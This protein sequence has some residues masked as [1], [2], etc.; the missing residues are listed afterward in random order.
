MRRKKG[1]RWYNEVYRNPKGDYEKD[2]VQYWE[3]LIECSVIF[4][5]DWREHSLRIISPIGEPVEVPLLEGSIL[6]DTFVFGH[7]AHII[8]PP[9][10]GWEL[11]I[12]RELW[13]WIPSDI[14]WEKTGPTGFDKLREEVYK[15]TLTAFLSTDS[16]SKEAK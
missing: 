11:S 1:F 14:E 5:E 10:E 6:N 4:E 8:A 12:V 2:G 16:P 15:R 9:Q 13:P 7:K 3:Y